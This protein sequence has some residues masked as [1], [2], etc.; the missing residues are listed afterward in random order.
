MRFKTRRIS[1]EWSGLSQSMCADHSLHLIWADTMS[2]VAEELGATQ[3]LQIIYKKIKNTEITVS[4]FFFKKKKQWIKH[5]DI[6][7]KI[8]MNLISQLLEDEIAIENTI[9]SIK[10]VHE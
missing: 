1:H 7:F 3:T 4:F 6:Y 9:Q 5:W 8:L 2:G 10:R